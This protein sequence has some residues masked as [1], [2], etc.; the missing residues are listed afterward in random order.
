MT[1]SLGTTLGFVAVVLCFISFAM[2]N[3]V[4]LRWL[5]LV[6]NIVFLAYGYLESQLPGLVLNAAL[7]PVNAHRL[8]EIY[9]LT[10]EISLANQESPV[11]QWLLPHM[12]RRP[13][14]AG[15]VLFRKGDPADEII[16]ISSGQVKIQEIGQVLGAGE[17]LGEIGLFSA[18]K[19]RTQSIVCETDGVLYRMTDQMIY[20]LY[21]QHP[22]L[23]FFFMRLI[24][25]RLL[26]D[27]QRA[28]ARAAG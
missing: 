10:K 27:I 17:L 13:F 3:M 21:Y 28:S 26:R 2:K 12:T 4:S 20:A 7:L 5:A 11:S 1:L 18:A 25:Q 14:K 16:Y 6:S 23:G 8:W 15:E 24:V 9:S 19:Q 22:K